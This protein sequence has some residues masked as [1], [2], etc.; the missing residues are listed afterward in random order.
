MG[1]VWWGR[2]GGELELFEGQLSRSSAAAVS[3]SGL[4]CAVCS[5]VD[6]AGSMSAAMCQASFSVVGRRSAVS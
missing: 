1:L 6:R 3:R 2:S 5:S 4:A